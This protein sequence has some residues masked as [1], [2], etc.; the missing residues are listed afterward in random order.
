[1]SDCDTTPMNAP[2][3]SVT[4]SRWKP[5]KRGRMDSNVSVSFTGKNW[6]FLARSVHDVVRRSCSRTNAEEPT[7]DNVSGQRSK[8][9]V[10][11][12]RAEGRR[13]RENR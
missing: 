10:A 13:R 1:M 6:C 4:G 5:L 8:A 12:E 7:S 9:L 2:L 11:E 3:L